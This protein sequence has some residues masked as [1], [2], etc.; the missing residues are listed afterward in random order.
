[1]ALL[2]R[3]RR[4]SEREDQ[5][6]RDLIM[7][8]RTILDGDDDTV[9]RVSEH[10]CGEPACGGQTVVLVMRPNQ[11]TKAVKIKKPL[12][13]VTNAD[14]SAALAPLAEEN[15]TSDLQSHSE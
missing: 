8:A 2:F 13:A 5:A 14:L 9:V 12:A 3:N 10:N 7:Q 6:A 4:V 11:P 1:M 15:Q